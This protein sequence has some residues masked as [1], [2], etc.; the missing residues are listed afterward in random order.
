M[1]HLYV[2]LAEKERR[3]ISE[4]TR[5]ALGAKKTSG[6]KLG[7]PS[8]IQLAGSLGRRVQTLLPTSSLQVSCPSS[9]QSEAPERPRSKALN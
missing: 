8:N 4:R 6:T 2:A 9:M 7:N 5:A 3:L 1:L